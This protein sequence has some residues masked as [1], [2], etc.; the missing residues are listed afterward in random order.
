[1]KL[2]AI[3]HLVLALVASTSVDAFVPLTFTSS[4]HR[5]CD[6]SLQAT[7]ED[8]AAK[9]Y[10][11]VVCGV[12]YAGAIMTARLAER[13]PDKKILAIE[14]GGYVQQATGGSLSDVADI[15]F[16]ADMFQNQGVKAARE[17]GKS[18]KYDPASPI[19]MPDVPGNYNNVAFRPLA[20]NGYQIPEFEACFQGAG[21]GGNGVYNGAL[22]Q[23]PANWWWDDDEVHKDIFLSEEDKANGRDVSDVLKPYFDRVQKELKDAIKTTPSMDGVHYNHGLYDLVKPYLENHKAPFTEVNHREGE[24]NGRQ[25]ELGKLQV[26]RD[27]QGDNLKEGEGEPGE[28]FFTVPAV[29]AKEGLRTG[30]SAWIEKF[31]NNKGESKFAN[32]DVVT[33]A[34]VLNVTLNDDKEVTGVYIMDLKSSKKSKH[35]GIGPGEDWKKVP[36]WKKQYGLPKETYVKVCKGG[37]IILSCNALPTNRILYKSGIGP[38]AIREEVMPSSKKENKKFLVNNEGVGTTINEHITTSLG[39]KYTG[40]DMPQPNTVH[41]GDSKDWVGNAEHLENYARNRSGPYAQFG[42]V[43]ASH[44]KADLERVKTLKE[45]KYREGLDDGKVTTELFYNPF[46]AGPYPPK[47]KPDLNPYNGPGTFT[48]YV[49]LLRPESRAFFKL[50]EN[51]KPE[52]TTLYMNEGEADLPSKDAREKLNLPDY[53]EFAARDIATMSASV[54]E[55]L[56]ITKDAPDI[57]INLGPGDGISKHLKVDDNDNQ[58]LKTTVADLDPNN[59]EDVK[60]YVTMYDSE[61]SIVNGEYLAI[62]HMEEN[63]YH[64]A[65]PLARNLDVFGKELGDRKDSYGLDPDTCEVKGT[66]GLCVVDAGMFPKAVYCHPIGSVMALAEWAADK[67]SPSEEKIA[68]NAFEKQST[69]KDGKGVTQKKTADMIVATA[70]ETIYSECWNDHVHKH[71]DLSVPVKERAANV[72]GTYAEDAVFKEL[73][74]VTNE[75]RVFTGRNEIQKFFEWHLEEIDGGETGNDEGD[76]LTGSSVFVKWAVESD[77]IKYTDS[78]DSFFMKEMPDGSAKIAYHFQHVNYEEK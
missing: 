38:E 1:M 4:T 22:Y 42:P 29:N 77:K 64:S 55:V 32:L 53:G 60:N 70:T 27:A 24:S 25:A 3:L 21:L 56:E 44:F 23:E 39:F 8:A 41:F 26:A 28:R 14:Y 18:T 6:V 50:D 48:T 31:L 11:F 35:G 12:G 58:D 73:N 13:N 66:K 51:D 61:Q 63:H 7:V 34:E 46:G 59:I 30:A 74:Y 40:K 54:H 37:K 43:V 33:H 9:E 76:P 68:H 17:D 19:T 71:N 5:S 72:A 78:A 75:E 69:A 49:M 47:S 20:E 10:D 36:G 45:E 65:V 16:Q 67:I 57:K 52:Y 2:N 62:T 15:G